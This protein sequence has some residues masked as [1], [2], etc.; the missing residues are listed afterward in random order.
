M[1]WAHHGGAAIRVRQEKDTRPDK[2]TLMIPVHPE[3]EAWKRDRSS[4]YI[5][6]SPRGRKWSKAH[7]SR[8][9]C[10]RVKALGFGRFTVHGLRKLAAARL[11]QAGCSTHEIAATGGWRSLSMVQHYTR[12]AEQE[13]LARGA[14]VRFT[15]AGKERLGG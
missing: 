6:T 8:E 4:V 5:L 12:A 15:N 1:T 14:V 7:L 13:K 10:K 11:A 3:L 9:L 2:P